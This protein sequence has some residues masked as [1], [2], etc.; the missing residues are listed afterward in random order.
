MQLNKDKRS[1][2]IPKLLFVMQYKLAVGDIII[3]QCLTG[4]ASITF[5]HENKC[6]H[7]NNNNNNN[8]IALNE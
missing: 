3:Y 1:I 4:V 2:H 7:Y 5:L 8:D 6:L